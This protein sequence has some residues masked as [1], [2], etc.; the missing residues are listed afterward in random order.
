[1]PLTRVSLRRGRDEAF[2]AGLADALYRAMRETVDVP[3]DDMFVM[4]H[5]HGPGEMAFG[6]RFMGIERS[7]DL[8][9]VE[10]TLSHGR[11]VEKKR[12]LYARIAALLSAE[13]SVRPEDV[14]VTLVEV[15]RANW[16]FGLGRAQY[17]EG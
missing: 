6:R 7:D 15:D 14:F 16:S 1:M 4:I 17:V 3:E 11:S 8:V 12:A 5:Q 13:L 10:I 2:L 9:V